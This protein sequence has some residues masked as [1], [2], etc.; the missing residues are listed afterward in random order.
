MAFECLWFG[1]LCKFVGVCV[2]VVMFSVGFVF[3]VQVS[4]R[5]VLLFV[6]CG[7]VVSVRFAGWVCLIAVDL[8]C[9]WLLGWLGVLRARFVLG[10][11]V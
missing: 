11:V 8:V 4:G 7:W 6:S 3:I 5:L 1:C 2:V 10:L 9:F